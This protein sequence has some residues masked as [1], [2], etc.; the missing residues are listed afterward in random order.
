[1]NAVKVSIL[2]TLYEMMTDLFC[3]E[4]SILSK[5]ETG[6]IRIDFMA[7]SHVK[8][9][10]EEISPPNYEIV[11]QGEDYDLSDL[12]SFLSPKGLFE[13]KLILIWDTDIPYAKISYEDLFN[14]TDMILAQAGRT[15]IVTEDLYYIF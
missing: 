15:F 7:V 11:F 1:M 12:K 14:A 5:E 13:R 9:W 4:Y 3:H 6:E 2:R 10:G 8:P